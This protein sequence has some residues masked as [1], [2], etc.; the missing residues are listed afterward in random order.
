VSC[1]YTISNTLD[2]LLHTSTL[3]VP[4]PSSPCYSSSPTTQIP[5]IWNLYLTTSTSPLTTLSPSRT[6]TCPSPASQRF[7]R[8][9]IH[10]QHNSSPPMP[11]LSGASLT[12][13]HLSSSYSQSPLHTPFA[14]AP[15]YLSTCRKKRRHAFCTVT[16]RPC[17]WEEGVCEFENQGRRGRDGGRARV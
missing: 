13:N 6:H 8:P 5:H 14:T 11:S 16:A 17:G 4:Y 7:S 12:S 10:H 9:A 15:P 3:S 1:T 2:E